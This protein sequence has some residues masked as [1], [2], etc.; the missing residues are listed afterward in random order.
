MIV[1][2][3]VNGVGFGWAKPV[4]IDPRYYKH[5]S[6]DSLLV[7][8]AGPLANILLAIFFAIILRIVFFQDLL[9]YLLDRKL[10]ELIVLFLITGFKLNISLAV[11]N[12]L[13]VPPLDGSKILR[14]S[15]KGKALAFFTDWKSTV[16]SGYTCNIIF[17]RPL[18]FLII[19]I[20][21]HLLHD[22]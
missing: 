5:P 22:Y 2:T 16:F 3:L 20:S 17:S 12:L 1:F 19:Y 18:S 8:L 13:P 6:R 7:A 10:A 4:Q 9:N 21:N 14:F 15:L 11:F